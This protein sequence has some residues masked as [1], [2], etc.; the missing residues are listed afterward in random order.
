VLCRETPEMESGRVER[1]NVSQ[2]D[3]LTIPDVTSASDPRKYFPC[4]ARTRSIS[5]RRTNEL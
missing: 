4:R 2:A 3:A 5:E 1:T